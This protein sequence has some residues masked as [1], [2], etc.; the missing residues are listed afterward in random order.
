MEPVTTV[1]SDCSGGH[2]SNYWCGLGDGPCGT[3]RFEIN[4]FILCSTFSLRGSKLNKVLPLP[5]N[6][7]SPIA[8]GKPL[9]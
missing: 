8:A 4:L 1:D 9:D 7:E 3:V 6:P 5:P 2:L